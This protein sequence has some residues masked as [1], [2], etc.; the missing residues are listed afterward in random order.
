MQISEKKEISEIIKR[1]YSHAPL[2]ARETTKLKYV[3]LK[4]QINKISPLLT[5]V[6]T[7]RF[8]HISSFNVS[9]ESFSVL[10]FLAIKIS[11]L[12]GRQ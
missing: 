2:S 9:F 12:T 5:L 6:N 7:F 4:Q 11:L 10:M 1:V 8:L 3:L